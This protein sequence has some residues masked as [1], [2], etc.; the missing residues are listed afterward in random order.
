M[1][2]KDISN[3]LLL[4]QGQSHSDIQTVSNLISFFFFFTKGPIIFPRHNKRSAAAPCWK[5]S[6]IRARTLNL[7]HSRSSLTLTSTSQTLTKKKHKKNKK[8]KRKSSIPRKLKNKCIV[9]SPSGSGRT[10]AF[11]IL[12]LLSCTAAIGEFQIGRF[13]SLTQLRFPLL[14]KVEANASDSSAAGWR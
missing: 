10:V 13:W 7:H 1:R 6:H 2:R 11:T 9:L 14:F 5:P 4:L 3:N 8:N 12:D